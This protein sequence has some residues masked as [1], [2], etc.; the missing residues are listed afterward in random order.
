MALDDESGEETFPVDLPALRVSDI[1]GPIVFTGG[2]DSPSAFAWV[3]IGFTTYALGVAQINKTSGAVVDDGT[4]LA[5]NTAWTTCVCVASA[6]GS[7]WTAISNGKSISPGGETVGVSLRGI[8]L[9]GESSRNIVVDRTLLRGG[10][11]ALVSGA[12][13]L[14]MGDTVTDRVYRI[15]PRT[16]DVKRFGLQQSAD[17]LV[18]ADGSLWV[19]D[20]LEGKVTRLG[21]NGQAGL[22]LALTGDLRDMAVGG[23]YVWVTDAS[24]KDV[25]RIPE[26]LGSGATPISVAEI[27]GQPKVVVYDDGAIVVGFEG[28][29]I[30]KI[31]PSDVSSPAVIWSHQ[32]G[33]NVSSITL[34][35][36][37]VW[38]AGPPTGEQ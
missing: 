32:V 8:D 33:Y 3:P 18:F 29:T 2:A 12:G 34:D 9:K 5:F 21:S 13:Y 27:G 1:V 31:N 20:T 37:I 16:S 24:G 15:N 17:V 22:T 14:W 6:E 4:G 10:V 35:R 36:G 23:G 28:G 7:L 30:A 11:S 25:Q 19:L 26:D 38:A